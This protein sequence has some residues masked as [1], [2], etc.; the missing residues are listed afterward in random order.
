MAGA[1]LEL[2]LSEIQEGLDALFKRLSDLTPLMQNI[3][4]VLL[5]SSQMRIQQ[6]KT[7]PDGAA[8]VPLSN[9]Y[10]KRREKQ[11]TIGNGILMVRGNLLRSLNYNANAEQVT[12]SMGGTGKSM[13]YA[14]I[15]Q[16]GGEI[17]IPPRTQNLK[18]DKN[19][20]FSKPKKAVRS[21][22]VQI[23][24]H[25][26]YIPARP[27]LGVSEQDK[28]DILAEVSDFLKVD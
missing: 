7:G 9:K 11:G 25:T 12:V 16:L 26:I 15:H 4:A 18:F 17:N 6:T 19:G 22:D 10:R 24:G 3:G 5:L 23:G 2:D 21:M 27:V 1:S 28:E 20:L 8:W 13:D 14:R